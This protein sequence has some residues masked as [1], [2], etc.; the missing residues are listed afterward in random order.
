[1]HTII[2]YEIEWPAK[3]PVSPEGDMLSDEIEWR[4]EYRSTLCAARSRAQ[5]T[6]HWG[7]VKVA[8]VTREVY[9]GHDT[10]PSNTD[11]RWTRD[12]PSREEFCA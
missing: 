6:C 12:T 7:D 11:W 4:R 3:V 2:R 10:H 9:R 1:M 8:Y 5:R